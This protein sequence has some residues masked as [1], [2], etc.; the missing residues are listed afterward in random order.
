VAK[1]TLTIETNDPIELADITAAIAE[2]QMPGDELPPSAQVHH[3]MEAPS[4]TPKPRGRPKK[5][6]APAAEQTAEPEAPV[7][8]K[9]SEASPSTTASPS[10]Q[11]VG[12]VTAQDCKLAL[13]A[14]MDRDVPP[15]AIQAALIEHFGAG[16]IMKIDASRYGELK[17][18][19]EGLKK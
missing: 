14:A 18:F 8:E 2:E 1:Y 17:T 15:A 10:N 4:E 7:S 6:D 5:A 12:D 13:N 3:Q 11:P 19:L 16:S 9:P